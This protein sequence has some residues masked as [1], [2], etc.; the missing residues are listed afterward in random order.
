M[1]RPFLA[2]ELDFSRSLSQIEI[3][4]G[5]ALLYKSSFF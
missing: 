5:R 1:H 4:R 3:V 2:A